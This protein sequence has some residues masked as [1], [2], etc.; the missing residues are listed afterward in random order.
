[1]WVRQYGPAILKN[2]RCDLQAYCSGLIAAGH[3]RLPDTDTQPTLS[4]QGSREEHL[5]LLQISEDVIREL[6]K[7][8]SVQDI[9][10]PMLMHPDLHKRNIYVSADDA[11]QITALI[12][13][14]STSIDPV[15]WHA[16]EQ[17]DFTT[18]PPEIENVLEGEDG[19]TVYTDEERQKIMR[20]VSIC[21]QTYEVVMQGYAR[22][23][24]QARTTDERLLRVILYCAT[25]W[26]DS[27]TALTAELI[28][29]SDHWTDVGLSGSCPYRPTSAERDE[30]KRRLEDF[31]TSQKLRSFLM[32]LTHANSEGWIPTS[33]WDDTQA[34]QKLAFDDW[35]NT[36]TGPDAEDGLTEEKARAL[37]PFDLVDR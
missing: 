17:P 20:D 8:P 18:G 13:W 10:E 35:M 15:F 32:Q 30:H 9:G 7:H 34:A 28:D 25:S 22:T 27:A 12:D 31:E 11:T 37:W 24:Y 6:I 23:L 21:R 4:F 16:T 5:R 14:Q 19:L 36:V 26:K 3:A 2:R 29:L 33:A 1:M